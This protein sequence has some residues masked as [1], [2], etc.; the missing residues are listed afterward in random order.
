MTRPT[1]SRPAFDPSVYLV[2]DRGLCG[3]RSLEDVVGLAVRGGAGVVQ[4]REKGAGFRAMVDL[5]LALK[6]LLAPF[7]VPLLINDRVD[8]AL[9]VGADGAHLGQSDMPVA[10][11]REL[12][13][14]QAILGLSLERLDQLAEAEAEAVDYYGVSP[15]FPTGT[16]NDLGAAWG[17]AGLR[18]LRAATSRPLVAI[19]GINADNAEA[20]VRAGADGLAVVSAI[21]AAPDPEAAS[22]ALLAAVR[23]GRQP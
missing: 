16:K 20:V 14:T 9:A 6:A 13:G 5:G 15:V 18:A 12:L 4:L 23:R 1:A 21:C 22:A 10:L 11:A 7:G 8:V 19:G 17:L 2:T 3:E